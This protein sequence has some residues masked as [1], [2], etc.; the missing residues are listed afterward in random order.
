[1]IVVK[2]NNNRVYPLS[3][4]VEFLLINNSQEVFDVEEFV[5]M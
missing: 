5:E 4:S 2:K 1:V 3:F